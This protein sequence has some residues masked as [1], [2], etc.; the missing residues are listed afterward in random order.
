[1]GGNWIDIVPKET[2]QMVNRSIKS[3]QHHWSSEKCKSKPQR[4]ITSHLLEGL[5]S[6]RQEITSVDKDVDK[7]EH[8][9][10]VARNVNCCR[11]YGNYGD[12]SKIKNKTTIWCSNSTSG[13]LSKG[14]KNTNLKRYLY[15]HICCSITYNSQDMEIT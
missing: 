12:C 7:R 11:H 6:K 3:T 9:P 4:D 15:P 13:Y 1:M 5:S 10:T 2:I 8:F 14:N